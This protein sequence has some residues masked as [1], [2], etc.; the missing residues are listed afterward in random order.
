M[1]G[2]RGLNHLMRK[3][4]GGR[5]RNLTADVELFKGDLKRINRMLANAKL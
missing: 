3:K 4:N 5:R 2:K 1:H